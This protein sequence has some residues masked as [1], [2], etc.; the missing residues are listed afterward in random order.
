[1]NINIVIFIIGWLLKFEAIFLLVPGVTGLCYKEG[2]PA[3][4]YFISAVICFLVGSLFT[5]RK[6]KKKILYT[7]E[8]FA[9]VGLA[10]VFVS[11]FGCIPFMLSGDIPVFIDAFFETV[12]GITTT[13]ASILSDVEVVSHA[14]LMWRSFLHWIGGMGVLVFLMA[15]LP[16]MGGSNMNLMRAESTG[17]SV[18]RLVPKVKDTAKILYTIYFTLTVFETIALLLCRL[19]VF[20]SLNIAF[21]TAGTGGFGLRNDSLTSYPLAVQNIVTVFMILFGVNFGMYFLLIRGQI[22][23]FFKNTEVKVYFAIVFLAAITIA[24]NIWHMYSSFWMALKDS[25]FQVGSIMTTTGFS[26]AD[27][28]LWP[29]YSKTVLV[30][31]M[32]VGACAGSTGGGI[33]VSRIVI[34]AK[35]VKQEILTKIHPK[36]MRDVRMDGR[37]VSPQVVSSTASY[38]CV[39][40]II[41]FVS[42][43]IISLENLDF[44][45]NFTAVAAML[46]N[47]GPGLLKVGPTCNF[48]FFSWWS[49]LVFIFDM[50]A[51][52]LELLP[53]L[54]LLSPNCWKK[55]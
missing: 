44:T 45:T 43:L 5:I 3:L 50:L 18:E 13:G 23:E 21:S 38:I 15:F 2:W 12:S 47:I 25:F 40:W 49:K 55:Y 24:L 14:G 51:G 11:L 10:W 34:T 37:A 27:F 31:L 54:I 46:N 9:T 52:R 7:R 32:F 4:S 19:S 53:F 28:D 6:P 35:A 36:M 20:E 17:P 30:T 26:T 16:L 42:M 8:G 29:E 33:K 39:Y 41:F 48:G 22:K 1:M